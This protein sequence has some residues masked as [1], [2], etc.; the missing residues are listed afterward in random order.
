MQALESITTVI[1]ASAVPEQ[2]HVMIDIETLNNDAC[3]GVILS[4]GA[5]KFSLTNNDVLEYPPDE[6]FVRS[7][8]QANHYEPWFYCPISL[9]SSFDAGLT[10]EA[11][12]LM[13]WLSEGREVELA[14]I[15]TGASEQITKVLNYFG[16]WLRQTSSYK[17]NLYVWSHGSTYDIVH[18]DNKYQ[19]ILHQKSPF[20]FRNVRD[21]RTLFALYRDTFGKDIEWPRKRKNHHPLEDSWA[22]ASSASKAWYQLSHR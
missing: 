7:G 2:F 1:K 3:H 4:I 12:T 10:I 16:S 22:Q 8:C 14:R 15:C 9:L 20:I 6:A 17:N 11:D 21:T 13:W 5:I 18:L 19:S